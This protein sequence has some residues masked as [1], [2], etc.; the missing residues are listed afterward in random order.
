MIS[1]VSIVF[2]LLIQSAPACWEAAATVRLQ[3]EFER[4]QT[5]LEECLAVRPDDADAL[6]QL[7]LT[8]LPLG[9]WDGAEQAFLDAL[10]I[11]PDYEDASIGLARLA[12]FRGDFDAA[13]DRLATVDQSRSDAAE[14]RASVLEARASASRLRSDRWRI[15]LAYSRSQLTEGLPD[16]SQVDVALGRRLG[17]RTTVTGR[18]SWA[19]RFER[20]DT[21]AELRLDH[22]FENGV[23]GY[24]ALGGASD[25]IFNPRMRVATGAE[26]MISANYSAAIDVSMAQYVSGEVATLSPGLYRILGD[27]IAR[28][29]GRL[30]VLRDEAGELRSGW[31]LS[32]E[33]SAR[34]RLRLVTGF[35]DA[36]ET[37]EGVTLD[38]RAFTA[39]ARFQVNDRTGLSVQAVHELRSAYDRTG[40]SV[41][42]SRRF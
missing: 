15:D 37:S 24:A 10:S 30:I 1:P 4:A 26:G 14:L 17:D 6:V 28:V 32:A 41:S 23:R 39:G 3:G 40:L 8:R 27:D 21:L 34:P 2:S 12:Y 33:W 5:I 29:G 38:V 20:Q 7:G 11:A 9:D 36:P 13:L 35:T 22:R 16:W 25:P 42:V 18:V 19:E 31:S